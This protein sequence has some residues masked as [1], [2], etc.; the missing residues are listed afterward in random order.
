MIKYNLLN[1]KMTMLVLALAGFSSCEKFKDFGDTNIDP[2]GSV[3]PVNSGLLTD[4]ELLTGT[5]LVGGTQTGVT[6]SLYAQQITETQYTEASLYSEPKF[7]YSITYRDILSNLQVIINRNTNDKTKDASTAYGSNANQVA[8]AS[9]LKTYIFWQL[10]DCWG[11]IPYSQALQGSAFLTPVYDKQEEI[12]PKLLAALK[13]AIAKFDNGPLVKG[14]IFYNGDIARWKKLANTLRMLISLR[15]IKVS[16]AAAQ[17]AFTDAFNDVAGYITANSDNLVINF[18]G[19][20]TYNHPWFSIYDGRTDYALS[21]TF[22]DIL[23]NMNDSRRNVFGSSA[24]AFPYGLKKTD[25]DNFG[26]ANTGYAR[27]LQPALRQK[28]SPFVLVNAASSLLAVS[29]AAVR[30][31]IPGASTAKDNY[32]NAVKASFEQWGLTQADANAVL[33]SAGN[34]NSGAGGGANI[35]ASSYN[36]VAGQHANTTGFLQRIFLQRYIAHFPDGIQVWSE[37]R[38]SCDLAQ[39]NPVTGTAGIPALGPT[40]FASNNGKGIPRRYV[41]GTNE[42]STNNTNVAA[43]AA[44]LSGGDV[45]G[46]RIWWDK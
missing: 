41:Y 30:G 4:A 23:T 33:N 38:R 45:A 24:T 26:A 8:V 11:D 14:D 3:S 19:D 40:A 10:T 42:Y 27:V 20:G 15:M 43:A 44:R 29:E 2:Y 13:E 9:I 25:A 31:W 39:P 7:E 36:S 1:P 37:W 34:F 16:P 22:S 17:T 6:S 46:A 28:N 5:V 21:K 18:P 12:Y 32:D 35:G